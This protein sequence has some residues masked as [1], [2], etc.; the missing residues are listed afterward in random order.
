MKIFGKMSVPDQIDVIVFVLIPEVV[1]KMYK[2][3]LSLNDEEALREYELFMDEE[4]D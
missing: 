3:F 4:S 2:D 1:F